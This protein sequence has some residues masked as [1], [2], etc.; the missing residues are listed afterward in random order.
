MRA[1]RFLATMS[2]PEVSRSRRWTSSRNFASGRWAQLLDDAEAHPLPPCTAS[3]AGLSSTSSGV[4]LEDDVEGLAHRHR[5]RRPL[6]GQ[7]DRR[8]AQSSPSCGGRSGPRACC[9]R[10]PRHCAG[11]GRCGSSARLADAHRKCRSADRH[12]LI[13]A[14]MGNGGSFTQGHLLKYTV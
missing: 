11:C 13:H 10:A 8:D 14:N 1:L 7:A 12:C 3:P 9:S 2:R 5:R 4:V 6:L